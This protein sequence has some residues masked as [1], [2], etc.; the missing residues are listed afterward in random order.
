MRIIL[1]G[2]EH[3]ERAYKSLCREHLH[4]VSVM[5]KPTVGVKRKLE[6]H[7]SAIFLPGAMPHKMLQGAMSEPRGWN[8]IIEQCPTGSVSALH[9]VLGKI[10]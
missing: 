9:K 5:T 1:S 4:E 6:Y 2:N 10:A 3:R 8:V 7:D